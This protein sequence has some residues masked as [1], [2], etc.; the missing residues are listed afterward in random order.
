MEDLISVGNPYCIGGK[1]VT[2]GRNYNY[3]FKF[4]YTNDNKPRKLVI[5]ITNDQKI[6]DGL[7]IYL[8]KGQNTYIDTTDFTTQKN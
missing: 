7:K 4:S 6:E 5:K 1:S 8:R 3:I 2:N